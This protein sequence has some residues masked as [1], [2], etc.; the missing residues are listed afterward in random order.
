MDAAEYK[1]TNAFA[2]VAMNE[3]GDHIVSA[4]I[5]TKSSETA[6]ETAIALALAHSQASTILSDSQ[7]AINNFAKGR[8]TNTSIKL[9]SATKFSPNYSELIWVPAHRGFFDR[10]VV[11]C[12]VLYPTKNS[13]ITYHDLTNHFKLKRRTFPPP[14]K[15]LILK[16][17]R[18]R[19][20]V[21]RRDRYAPLHSSRTFILTNTTQ[22]VNTA[23][24][25]PTTTISYGIAK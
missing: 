8:I 24:N 25:E 9:L 12:G 10:A 11:E 1:R 14:H 5:K 16:N 19:G 4:T 21:S 13:M 23:A 17:R 7:M 22:S 3:N 2:I 18:L 15:S 20:V 6:E